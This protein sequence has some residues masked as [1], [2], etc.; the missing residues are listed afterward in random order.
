ME[1]I[2]LNQKIRTDYFKTQM[3]LARSHFDNKNRPKAAEIL[4][5]IIRVFGDEV[6]VTEDEYHP[7]IVALYRDAYRKMSGMQKGRV[8]V[9]TEPAGAE[10]LIHGKPQAEGTPATFDGIY[11]G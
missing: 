6:K 4:E 9:R 3:M 8:M 1:T 7:D 10:V 2:S 11:P 5:E